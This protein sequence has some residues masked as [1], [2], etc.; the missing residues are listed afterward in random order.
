MINIIIQLITSFRMS[1]VVIDQDD[2]SL[3]IGVTQMVKKMEF[4]AS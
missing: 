1:Y 3:G 4:S 2:D